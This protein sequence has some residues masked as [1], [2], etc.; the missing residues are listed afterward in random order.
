[1]LLRLRLNY[2]RRLLR[3]LSPLLLRLQLLHHDASYVSC[4]VY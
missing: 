2:L 1:M 3:L 4:A